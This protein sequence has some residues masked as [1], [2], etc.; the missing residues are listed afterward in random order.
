M[1]R[2]WRAL[3]ALGRVDEAASALDSLEAPIATTTLGLHGSPRCVPARATFQ[4]EKQRRTRRRSA[5]TS[6]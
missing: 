1:V 4:K 5:S 3:L 2:R 6:A